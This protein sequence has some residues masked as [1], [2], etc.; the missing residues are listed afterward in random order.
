[1]VDRRKMDDRRLG[2][3]LAGS[4]ILHALFALFVPQFAMSPSPAPESVETISFKKIQHVS[5]RMAPAAAAR[6]NVVLAHATPRPVMP[7]ASH[8]KNKAPALRRSAH[9]TAV[10]TPGAAQARPAVVAG[11]NTPVPS[12]EPVQAATPAAVARK[13]TEQPTAASHGTTESGGSGILGVYQDP[14]LERSAVDDLHRRFK[15]DLTLVVVVGDD[16]KTKS[17]EFHPPLG[18]DTEKQIRELLADAH[19]DTAL[20]GG[21]LACEGTATIKLSAQ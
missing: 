8:A 4:V 17:V 11:A 7:P 21:G 5:V 13:D 19:W 9:A 10:H 12:Q 16:G 1:M 14:V 15:V 18:P 3:A 6:P 20:C 2:T